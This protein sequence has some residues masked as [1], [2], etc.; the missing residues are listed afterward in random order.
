MICLISLIV[1][2][3][4][5]ISYYTKLSGYDI[6]QKKFINFSSLISECKNLT[7]VN[8]LLYLVIALSYFFYFST[9]NE[10]L[11]SY[12]QATLYVIFYKFISL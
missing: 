11:N 7:S 8:N 5:Q 3:N 1:I 4:L 10:T 9:L 12:A 6:E 2:S